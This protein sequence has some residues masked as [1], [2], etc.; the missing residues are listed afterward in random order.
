MRWAVGLVVLIIVVICLIAWQM[1]GPPVNGQWL[2]TEQFIQRSGLESLGALIK[3]GKLTLVVAAKGAGGSK[4]L[5]L[6]SQDYECDWGAESVTTRFI[7]SHTTLG[8]GSPPGE[9]IDDGTYEYKVETIGGLTTLVIFDNE[10]IYL[11]LK[12]EH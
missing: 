12:K 6:C 5:T 3:G 11:H 1:A 7:D 9:V 2:A 4:S 8:T 10:T